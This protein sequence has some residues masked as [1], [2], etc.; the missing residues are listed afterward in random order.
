MKGKLWASYWEGEST[1][2]K[3]TGKYEGIKGK[4]TWKTYP[5]SPM[6]SYSDE[7]HEI[8]LPSR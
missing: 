6:Q 2:V 4:G 3:G 7:V 1:Y 5:V 8:G